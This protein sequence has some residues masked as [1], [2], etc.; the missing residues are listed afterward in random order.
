MPKLFYLK[1]WHII[2]LIYAPAMAFAV[3]FWVI[4]DKKMIATLQFLR[5]FWIQTGLVIWFWEVGHYLYSRSRKAK[6]WELLLFRISLLGIVLLESFDLLALL[7]AF[8]PFATLNRVPLAGLTDRLLLLTL[9]PIFYRA[10]FVTR[11]LK[12]QQ[13]DQ[14]YSGPAA[15][16]FASLLLSPIGILVIQPQLNRLAL[17]DDSK[18]VRVTN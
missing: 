12:T 4:E 18:T 14:R 2:L 7:Q 15:P 10:F 6:A 16:V 3:G 5:S 9:L 11:Y 13:L 8:F 1:H 17:R